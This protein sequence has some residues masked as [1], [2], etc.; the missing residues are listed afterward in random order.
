MRGVHPRWRSHHVARLRP[1]PAPL[2]V[3]DAAG[4]R[5][6][7]RPQPDA[8]EDVFDLDTIDVLA[9]TNEHV[10]H[11]VNDVTESLFIQAGEIAGFYPAVDEGLR[12]FIWSVPVALHHLWTLDPELTHSICA[13]SLTIGPDDFS[14]PMAA[15]SPQL[16]GRSSYSSAKWLV[17]VA[18]VSLIPQPVPG[19]AAGNAS[20]ILR[21]S[22]GAEGAPPYDR[23]LSEERS[24]WV[25][26]DA[27]QAA[28]RSSA[29][30]RSR[31][32]FPV[33]STSLRGRHPTVASERA[34][35]LARRAAPGPI[36]S[37]SRGTGVSQA[38]WSAVGR[39][40]LWEVLSSTQRGP[41]IGKPVGADGGADVAV[42]GE[43]SL[44][45]A[46]RSRGVEDRGLIVRLDLHVGHDACRQSFHSATGPMTSSSRTALGSRRFPSTS[47]AGCRATKTRSR[48]L[49]VSR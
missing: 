24:Y 12:R 38:K 8:H 9:A 49:H 40:R 2:P 23:L 16:S 19:A 43:G 48:R 27:R 21:T 39:I 44:R 32:P 36:C 5:V 46:R 15:A 25:A 3:S 18:E 42:R 11:T 28:K 26:Q 22:S 34:W 10:F 37:R 17:N 14:S 4:P 45:L 47:E 31:R 6:R 30:L 13:Q 35:T 33:R 20:L 1:R 41:G 29:R 7:H